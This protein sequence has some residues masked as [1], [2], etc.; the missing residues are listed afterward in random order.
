VDPA[1]VRT[2]VDEHLQARHDH[3]HRLWALLT[4]ELWLRGMTRSA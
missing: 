2:L 4:F 1:Y 3:G